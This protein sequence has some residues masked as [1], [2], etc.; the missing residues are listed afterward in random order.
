[1]RTTFVSAAG[2]V[3]LSALAFA[4]SAQAQCWWN[5]YD[6]SCSA[7]PSTYYQPAPPPVY[8]PTPYAAWNAYD[9]RDYR[10]DPR[11]LPSY[12]GPRASSGWGW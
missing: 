12:P 8:G 11:W 3:A 9:Y 5:G 10:Y 6:Y 2:A 4:G 1:M 7:P